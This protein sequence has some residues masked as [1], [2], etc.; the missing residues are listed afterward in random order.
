MGL[1]TN[2]TR[3]STAMSDSG[4]PL[5]PPTFEFLL[6]SLKTRIEMRLGLLS[7]GAEAALTDSP[8]QE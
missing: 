2:Y 5:T 4:F 7:F 1:S 3:N 8:A 6:F